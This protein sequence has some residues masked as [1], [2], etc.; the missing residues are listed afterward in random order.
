[1]YR[2][3]YCNRTEDLLLNYERFIKKVIGNSYRIDFKK[4]IAGRQ[5]QAGDLEQRR[6]FCSELIAKSFKETKL[7]ES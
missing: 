5:T 4:I 1:M 3:L 7:L 2:H 6:F